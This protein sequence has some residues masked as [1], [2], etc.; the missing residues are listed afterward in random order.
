MP[1][2]EERK[3]EG[4]KSRK[5]QNKVLWHMSTVPAITEADVKMTPSSKLYNKTL[6]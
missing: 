6:S 5:E 2:E 4:S 1:G 3:E